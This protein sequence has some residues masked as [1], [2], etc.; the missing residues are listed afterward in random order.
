MQ[1]VF[2]TTVKTSFRSQL[3][4]GINFL[5]R[6]LD[7]VWP[8]CSFCLLFQYLYV[9]HKQVEKQVYVFHKQVA[10]NRHGFWNSCRSQFSLKS[11]NLHMV[12]TLFFIKAL[13]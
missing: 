3:P 5:N 6:K 2:A 13:P 4:T 7:S 8:V 12:S 11:H 10:A 9:F 1:H